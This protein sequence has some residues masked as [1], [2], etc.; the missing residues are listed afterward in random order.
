MNKKISFF[1]KLIVLLFCII[2]GGCMTT[3]GKGIVQKEINPEEAMDIVQKFYEILFSTTPPP[4]CPDIFEDSFGAQ[5]SRRE[6]VEKM[7]SYI[8]ENQNLFITDAY[9][10]SKYFTVHDYF[11]KAKKGIWYFN[12]PRGDLA[13]GGLLYVTVSS[14]LPIESGG[15]WK[16]V[17]IPVQKSGKT[18]DVG[19]GFFGIR[20]NGLLL[21]YDGQYNREYNLIEALGFRPQ[22]SDCQ[23]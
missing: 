5:E 11:E 7:W 1:Q 8:R 18:G 21:E 13:H 4:D 14:L 10:D 6:E 16:D 15:V 19:I 12:L 9:I 20:V 22:K 17:A 2:Q 3:G 23:R